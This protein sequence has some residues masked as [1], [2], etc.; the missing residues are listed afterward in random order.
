MG[1]IF[2]SDAFMQ[3]LGHDA[4]LAG[5]LL[6]AYIEDSTQRADMLGEA[7]QESDSNTAA[8][9]AHSLKGMSGVVRAQSLVDMAL[10]MEATSKDGDLDRVREVYRQFREALDAGLH[11]MELFLN[12][13]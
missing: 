9:T 4:E 13:L 12:S 11:E 10:D 3:S 1:V 8:K 7:L 6:A 5:E 2:D